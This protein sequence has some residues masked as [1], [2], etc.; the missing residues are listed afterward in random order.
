[1]LFLIFTIIEWK[2]I[3]IGDTI[4]LQGHFNS[5]LG[6]PKSGSSPVKFHY[7]EIIVALPQRDLQIH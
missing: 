5:K 7:R 1:M 3:Q 2:C 4:W 6:M